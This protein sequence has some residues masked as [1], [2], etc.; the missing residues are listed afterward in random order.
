MIKLSPDGKEEH[1]RLIYFSSNGVSSTEVRQLNK[2]KIAAG[3]IVPVFFL[4]NFVNFYVVCAVCLWYNS[5]RG[6]R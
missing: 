5:T 6:D 3:R 2:E 4:S 1:A